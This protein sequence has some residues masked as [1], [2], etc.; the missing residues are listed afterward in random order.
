MID[1]KLAISIFVMLMGALIGAIIAFVFIGSFV[2]WEAPQ[3]PNDRI[4]ILVRMFSV[5]FAIVAFSLSI[6]KAP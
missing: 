3:M 5:V 1:I 2:L 6:K 4:F